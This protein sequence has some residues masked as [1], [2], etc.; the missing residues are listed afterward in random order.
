M[1]EVK[2]EGTT[3]PKAEKNTFE[4]FQ[5]VG[6]NVLENYTRKE[7]RNRWMID[8]EYKLVIYEEGHL[9]DYNTP[10]TT[11]QMKSKTVNSNPAWFVNATLFDYIKVV[12]KVYSIKTNAFSQ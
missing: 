7:I 2:F 1:Y 10:N 6:T 9:N 12:G 8:N 4:G 3:Q 5:I 11:K